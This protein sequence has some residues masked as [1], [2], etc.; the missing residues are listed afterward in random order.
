[1][2]SRKVG[3]HESRFTTLVSRTKYLVSRLGIWYQVSGIK[4]QV[5]GKC[6]L[7]SHSRFLGTH[8]THESRFTIHDR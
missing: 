4:Y 6:K 1:M 3:I 2:Q 7:A 8:H 5:S